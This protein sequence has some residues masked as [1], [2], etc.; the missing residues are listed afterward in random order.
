MKRE[1]RRALPAEINDVCWK[2]SRS[3]WLNNTASSEDA[4]R[5]V[6]YTSYTLPR[7]LMSSQMYTALHCYRV[8][9]CR[10]DT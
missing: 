6:P 7:P 10:A 2:S 4:V 8:V 9:L 3:D 5:Y 1:V